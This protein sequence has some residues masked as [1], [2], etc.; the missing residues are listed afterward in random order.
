[1]V[2]HFF[3]WGLPMKSLYFSAAVLFLT[4]A[5]GHA[6]QDASKTAAL[7]DAKSINQRADGRYDVTCL[8][9][10]QQIVTAQDLQS[11]NVCIPT[12]PASGT[13][14]LADR[15][16][17]LSHYSLSSPIEVFGKSLWDGWLSFDVVS[18]YSDPIQIVDGTGAVF[19]SGTR[20]FERLKLPVTFK[21]QP[22]TYYP[23]QITNITADVT[24]VNDLPAQ[25]L[26][27]NFAMSTTSSSVL[28][29]TV[30]AELSGVKMSFQAT[31]TFFDNFDAGNRCGVLKFVGSDH[32]EI[33]T[34]ASAYHQ[35]TVLGPLNIYSDTSCISSRKSQPQNATADFDLSVGNIVLGNPT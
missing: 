13:I 28:L 20:R 29:V 25:G 7:S 33:L 11:N 31:S 22:G 32:T 21:R 5:C 8:D 1:M 15:S 24:H 30:G 3:P 12:A 19:S 23:I 26:T 27:G 2:L 35:I 17:D 6:D 16:Y 34:A 10:R 14:K 4:Q 9:N 18:Q